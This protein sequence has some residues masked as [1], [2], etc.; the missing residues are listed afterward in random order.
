MGTRKLYAIVPIVDT[1]LVGAY[2]Q[3]GFRSEGILDR[4]YNSVADA[5]VLSKHIE[6]D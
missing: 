1:N 3:S 4:P 2:W 6:H 5:V